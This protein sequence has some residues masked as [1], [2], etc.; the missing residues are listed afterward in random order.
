VSGGLAVL[1]GRIG[2]AAAVSRL[3]DQQEIDGLPGGIHR[4]VQKPVAALDADIR[5]PGPIALFG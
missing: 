2:C 3:G 5:L 4:A 1:S